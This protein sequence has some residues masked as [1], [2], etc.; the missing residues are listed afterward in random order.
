MSEVELGHE[1][2]PQEAVEALG[3]LDERELRHDHERYPF[4]RRTRSGSLLT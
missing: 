4:S 3:Q 2:P 1:L